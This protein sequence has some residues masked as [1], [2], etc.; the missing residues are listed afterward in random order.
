MAFL[1]HFCSMNFLCFNGKIVPSNQ[2]ILPAQNRGFRYG[3]GLFET[4]KF[5]KGKLHLEN[6]HFDRLFFGMDVLQLDKQAISKDQIQTQIAA[7]TE[8]N[9]C[10]N[11]ARVRLA[12]FRSDR[13]DPSYIIE[14]FSLAPEINQ[15]N[16]KGWVIGLHPVVRKGMD[17]LSNLK[18]ANYLPY[19]LADL[20]ARE[21]GWD[22]CLLLNGENKLCD[23]SKANIFLVINN[24]V[25]TP[26]LHQGCVSGVM[27]RFMIDQLKIMGIRIHQKELD[28]EML[29]NADE[30]FLT[31]AI[32]GIR[33]IERFKGKQ[34]TNSFIRHLYETTLGVLYR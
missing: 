15:L 34:Y 11:L 19:V 9:S 10:T 2:P 23:A 3:D 28:E 31:N 24:E 14:A 27:R 1:F 26:A 7:L 18:T 30:V 5:F 6:Y 8:S 13:G 33:W 4:M 21:K 12:V 29:L 25:Y 16:E 32:N 17:V 20:F 22:E